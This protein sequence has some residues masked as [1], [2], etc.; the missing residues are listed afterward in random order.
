[1]TVFIHHTD[2]PTGLATLLINLQPQLSPNDD[3]YIVDSSKNRSGLKI[4]ELYGTTRSY[5]FVEVGDYNIAQAFKFAV[6][7]MTENKQEGILVISDQCIVPYTFIQ[8]LKRAS[9]TNEVIAPR[10]SFSNV[11]DP[12]FR[13]FS[14]PVKLGEQ[15]LDQEFCCY[16]KKTAINNPA[17]VSVLENEV[18]VVLPPYKAS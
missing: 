13:W 12:N 7:S 1:M 18:V 4:A 3:V 16:F 10:V 15:E 11:M 17:K 8:S 9:K 2:N 6:Q 5:I 14:H